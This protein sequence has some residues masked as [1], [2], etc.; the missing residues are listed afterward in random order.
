MAQYLEGTE[1][2]RSRSYSPAVV[3]EG[4]RIVWMADQTAL[5]DVDGAD[6]SG[7][8][9]A[10][11]HRVFALMDE[12]LRRVGGSL[13]DLVTMTGVHQ[14][15][16]ARRPFRR[17]PRGKVRRRAL[18]VQRAHQRGQLRAAWDGNRDSGHRGD[19]R[20]GVGASRPARE[21]P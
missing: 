8:F 17:D 3:T 20:P 9:E 13:A 18:P 1:R 14:G 21:S 11:T 2:Q 6:I 12:T 19:R 5:A 7:N 15:T 4:G 16:A 10:Q